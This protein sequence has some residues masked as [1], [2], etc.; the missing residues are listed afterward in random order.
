MAEQE[1]LTL[2]LTTFK[3]K[4]RAKT[5]LKGKQPKYEEEIHRI[6]IVEYLTCRKMVKENDDHYYPPMRETDP[7]I[8]VDTSW[9]KIKEDTTPTKNE[10]WWDEYIQMLNQESPRA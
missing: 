1:E 7:S 6:S 8:L 2:S 5:S 10:S 3:R 9:W 4:I